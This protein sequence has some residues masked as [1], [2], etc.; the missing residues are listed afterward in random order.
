MCYNSETSL[1]TFIIALIFSLILILKGGRTDK[2]IGF[3]SISIAL[4]QFTEF[5]MWNS[6]DCGKLNHFSTI[7]SDYVLWFQPISLLFFSYY[8][9]TSKLPNNFIYFSLFIL[10]TVLL[11]RSY[12]YLT[13]DENVNFC[14]K[15]NDNGNLVWDI[16]DNWTNSDNIYVWIYYFFLILPMFFFKDV[17]KGL[18]IFIFGFLTIR[19]T[20]Y[21]HPGS[22]W[23]SLWCLT[24]NLIPIVMVFYNILIY[25]NKK[26]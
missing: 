21:Y 4:M 10:L 23:E 5:L 26:I 12:R 25:V 6:Q 16:P 2:T 15:P 9:K 1:T 14:S 17:I 11:I 18:I 13:L 24:T 19:L 7:L 22:G 20:K 8:F 3:F